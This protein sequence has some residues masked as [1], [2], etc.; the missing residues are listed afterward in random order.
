MSLLTT[1]GGGLMGIIGSKMTADAQTDANRASIAA[2]ERN[3]EKGL[4]GLTGGGPLKLT[5]RTPEGGFDVK[6]PGDVDAAK[7]RGTL[8]FGDIDRALKTNTLTNEKPTLP[9]L[10]DA[11]GVIDRDISRRQR[12]FDDG[13]NKLLEAQK[14]R[15][16][17]VNNT[18]ELPNSIT[19]LAKYSDANKF[20][21]ERDAIDL[22]TKTAANDA[23]VAAA[24]LGN[25][26]PKS[27]IPSFTDATPGT[28]AAQLIASTK[29]PMQIADVGDAAPFLGGQAIFKDLQNQ[30]Y[31]KDQNILQNKILD[32]L[33]KNQGTP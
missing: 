19:A 22:F 12:S 3:Q 21:R 16:D 11:T 14:R 15:F 8:A 18:G 6:Q 17:G 4:Q 23:T 32:R 13:V 31:Q 33:L 29:P 2:A 9:T 24:K 20:N 10:A 1:I 28:S 26:A 25:L 27:G 5:T 7:A 30:A